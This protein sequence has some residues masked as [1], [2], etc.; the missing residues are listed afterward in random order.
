LQFVLARVSIRRR[1]ELADITIT[2]RFQL[3]DMSRS[4]CSPR[5][6]FV[7]G[8]VVKT[9]KPPKRAVKIKLTKKTKAPPKRLNL[10]QQYDEI[11]WLRGLVE[12]FEGK[13]RKRQAK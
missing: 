12:Y 13:D 1:A 3:L 4:D 10:S 2:P 9:T 8:V 6:G 7:W 11:K 5:C